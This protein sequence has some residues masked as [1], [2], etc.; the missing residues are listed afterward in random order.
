MKQHW[1][2]TGGTGFLGSA[3]IASLVDSSD[4]ITILTR[5]PEHAVNG[6]GARVHAIKSLDEIGKDSRVDIIV[7][8]AGEP[9]FPKPWTKNRVKA[10]ATSR[11]GTTRQL[12]DLIERLDRAP[13]T[14]ISGSAIGFYGTSLDRV[15]TETSQPGDDM[16]ASLCDDWEATAKQAER[17]RV[18]LIRTGLVLDPSGGL[19][20]PQVLAAKLGGAAKLG[21]GQHWQSWISLDDWV[22]IVHHLLDK[23]QLS[24]PFNATAPNPVRQIDFADTL[25]KA[26]RRPRFF[27]IPALILRALMG[28]QS[29]LL[30]E[31]QKVLPE[32]LIASGF[33][34]QD[35]DL[36][37]Y[38]TEAFR[39]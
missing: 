22:R 2:I 32:R 35:P 23:D 19:L 31:G 13:S 21:D 17:T 8:L 37:D 25:A 11:H 34:F 24:G 33:A 36:S 30:L 38:M 26:L 28:K 15:F 4:E 6:F 27:R 39:K 3:L 16:L 5:N 1:L 29:A 18:C 7:N 10:F 9:L 20:G 14:F 12:V